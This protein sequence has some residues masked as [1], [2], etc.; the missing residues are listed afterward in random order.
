MVSILQKLYPDFR[1]PSRVPD[2]LFDRGN[3]S[4]E[5]K[6]TTSLNPGWI[7]DA[8]LIDHEAPTLFFSG[9]LNGKNF[10]YTKEDDVESKF[11]KHLYSTRTDRPSKI[12]K[13]KTKE[14]KGKS[15][16]DVRYKVIEL[17]DKCII[18]FVKPSKEFS[19][20]LI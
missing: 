18:G 1:Y 11:K 2:L 20:E 13:I 14:F 7:I 8:G 19:C 6:A 17:D 12:K 16:I 5:L 4:I 3:T 15:S 9:H 10:D